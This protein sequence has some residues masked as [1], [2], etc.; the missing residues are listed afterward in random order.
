MHLRVYT[1]HTVTITDGQSQAP[2]TVIS[3]LQGAVTQLSSLASSP[4]TVT[5]LT[6]SVLCI[7]TPKPVLCDAISES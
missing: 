5:L 2:E 6:R 3:P 4:L 1:A 7:V